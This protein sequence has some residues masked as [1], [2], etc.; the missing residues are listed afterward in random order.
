DPAVDGL[1]RWRP[2]QLAAPVQARL[3]VAALSGL[4][5]YQAVTGDQSGR[6]YAINLSN[7]TLA[8]TANGGAPLGDRV[9]A[10]VMPN[11]AKDRLFFGTRNSSTTSNKVYALNASNGSVAWTYAPGDLDII[12]G[13][14]VIDS[15]AGRLYVVSRGA[16]GT[17]SFRVLDLASGARIAGLALGDID[18][19]LTRDSTGGRPLVPTPNS[20]DV[21]A[22]DPAANAAV[23]TMPVGPTSSPAYVTGNGFLASL[24]SGAVE[25]YSLV[26]TTVTRLWTTPIANPSG[27]VVQFSTQKIFVGSSDGKVHQLNADTG[28]DEKQVTVSSQAVGMPAID[29]TSNR[30]HV[31]TLD[32]RLCAF[33]LPFP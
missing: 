28:V 1:E 4:S 17:E 22:I 33:Q 19:N 8:W 32:G 23:W 15:V 13:G 9:Q 12:S 21:S 26:G 29:S 25:R 24:K 14:T 6:V 20:G 16:G 10:F 18:Y 27:V 30:L 3:T 2:V 7:G 5:G 11:G 31:G